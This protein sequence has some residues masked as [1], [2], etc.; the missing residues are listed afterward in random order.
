MKVKDIFLIKIKSATRRILHTAGRQGFLY[1]ETLNTYL[2]CAEFWRHWTWGIIFID[3]EY[4]LL[5]FWIYFSS[6]LLSSHT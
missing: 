3:I 1:L 2:F 4:Y 5:P 6:S